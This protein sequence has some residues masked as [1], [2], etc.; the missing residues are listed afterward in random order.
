MSNTP[1]PPERSCPICGSSALQLLET[2]PLLHGED[3]VA[4]VANPRVLGTNF[5]FQCACGAGFTLSA[6]EPELAHR[7]RP[8]Q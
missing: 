1:T 3:I 7:N 8:H 6:P 4:A 5:V 2:R